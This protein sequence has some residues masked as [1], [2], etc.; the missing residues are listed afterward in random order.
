MEY[1]IGGGTHG[2]VERHSVQEGIAGSYRARQN[3]IVTLL[4]IL[5]CVLDYQLGS[6]AE[7]LY[8]IDVS[9]QYA[10]VARQRESDSLGQRVHR[11][12]REHAR[13]GAAAWACALLN[14]S[15]FFVSHRRIAA[16]DHRRYQVGI[17]AA[18]LSGLHRTARAEHAGDVQS[19]SSHQHT[20]RHFVAVRDANHGVGLMSVYHIFYRVGNDVARG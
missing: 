5:Q 14:L 10:A 8:A 6:I 20:R 4:V 11:V 9:S 12:C 17:L 13:T 1:G 18:P 19:H 15:Q 16:L 2:D 3:A 7:Q